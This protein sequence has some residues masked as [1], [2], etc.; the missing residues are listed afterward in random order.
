M[1][2]ELNQP[3]Q[4]VSHSKDDVITSI[5]LLHHDD[6]LM[7]Y[8]LL[9]DEMDSCVKGNCRGRCNRKGFC[10]IVLTSSKFKESRQTW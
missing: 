1:L 7:S 5:P 8:Y 2:Q 9:L 6:Q 4:V 10:L 3:Y